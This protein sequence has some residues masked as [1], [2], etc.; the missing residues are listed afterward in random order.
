MIKDFLAIITKPVA[1]FDKKFDSKLKKVLI[2]L[3]ILVGVYFVADLI[4]MMYSTLLMSKGWDGKMHFEVLKEINYLKYILEFIFEQVI[5]FGSI[6]V[7]IFIYTSITKKDFK[8]VDVLSLILVAYTLNYLVQAATSIIFM[9]DFT[10]IK[11][12]NT[13]ESVLLT[14]ADYYS[15]AI[16]VLGLQKLFG[17]KFNDKDLISLVIMFAVTFTVRY[18]LYLA[19]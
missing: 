16:I 1:T 3:G 4:S 2:L 12:L 14:T 7:G 19:I 5:F 13:I 6:F 15:I 17:F 10:N 18:L 11:I 9:F 8:L